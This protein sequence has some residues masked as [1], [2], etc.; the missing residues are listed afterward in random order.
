MNA[1]ES[2]IV[3]TS[4]ALSFLLAACALGIA[5][6]SNAASYSDQ[7]IVIAPGS[8]SSA[9][10]GYCEAGDI[11]VWNWWTSDDVNFAI[12][13]VDEKILYFG[14][15]SWDGLVVSEPG[16]YSLWWQNNDRYLTATVSYTA[17]SFTPSLAV[18]YPA[19]GVYM[20]SSIITVRGSYDGYAGGILVGLDP[21]H[22]QHAQT[23]GTDWRIENLALNEGTNTVLVQSYYILDDYGAKYH[24]LSRTVRV[25]VDT[26]LPYLSIRNPSQG[27]FSTGHVVAY[28][29]C[30]D[31]SGVSKQEIQFDDWDWEMLNYTGYIVDLQDGPH[32]MRVKVTD[33]AGN[34]V[35]RMV[36]FDVDSTSPDLSIISPA[37]DSY[38]NGTPVISWL[39]SDN[40]QVTRQE[41]SIDS[42]SWESV[43][44]G[45]VFE[46]SE[47]KHRISVRIT[48][49][50]GNQ[51]VKMVNF[52]KDISPPAI[53]S[54][55]PASGS[56]VPGSVHL[57]WSSSDNFGVG[58]RE[59]RVDSS[60]W[61][62][63]SIDEA[64]IDLT[65]GVH[66]VEVRVTDHAGNAAVEETSVI[67]DGTT[68]KV[69]V[70]SPKTN[71]RFT[72]DRVIVSWTGSDELS[73][74]DHY[75]VQITDGQ[76]IDVG[77]ATSYEFANLGDMWYFVSVKAVDKSGNSAT[78]TIRFSINT[79]FWSSN[80]PYH[81]IPSH[82]LTA[83]V[84]AVPILCLLW[85]RRRKIAA[86]ISPPKEP[87]SE[88]LYYPPLDP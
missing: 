9:P 39:T 43:Q 23:Q 59:V 11:V 65:D 17:L 50:A 58:K 49:P 25:E 61:Q 74:I 66:T 54:L 41:V 76:W 33:Y 79:N 20:N 52:T 4:L 3:S 85:F 35:V 56:Y 47:G 37:E 44:S 26:T 2:S 46:G 69:G 68:P 82:A 22:L 24:I 55:A 62:E 32:V 72:N 86:A 7:F 57:W 84:I 87:S 10:V 36:N 21:Y 80:G 30:A 88:T 71:S 38:V 73:G 16:N 27:S 53:A 51:V 78:S 67:S 42:K 48:D 64:T 83:L 8:S 40:Y 70:V 75:E 6:H 15:G 29:R 60:S 63:V 77:T 18:T 45:L 34:Q 28:W 19:N 81:G 14:F 13:D 1:R 12:M 31:N 5:G